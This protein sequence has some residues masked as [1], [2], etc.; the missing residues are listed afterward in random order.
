MAAQR[1]KP[2]KVGALKRSE[3]RLQLLDFR[4]VSAQVDRL[5]R[6][7]EAPR[8]NFDSE[9]GV[10]AEITQRGEDKKPSQLV[11]LSIAMNLYGFRLKSEG[12]KDVR[13]GQSFSIKTVCEAVFGVMEGAFDPGAGPEQLDMQR[14]LFEAHPLVLYKIREYASDMGFR[15][16]RPRMGMNPKADFRV[17]NIKA[18]GLQA[19]LEIAVSKNKSEKADDGGRVTDANT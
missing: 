5:L 10:T 11:M 8:G 12:G 18:A 3:P 13:D 14:L 1:K 4:T 7:D 6:P 15:G 19:A 9:V 2:S 16:V 17:E